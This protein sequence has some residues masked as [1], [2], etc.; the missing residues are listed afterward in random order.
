MNLRKTIRA[1]PFFPFP[2]EFLAAMALRRKKEL[3]EFFDKG[4]HSSKAEVGLLRY[5]TGG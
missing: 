5:R 1:D 4:T 2:K 3:E